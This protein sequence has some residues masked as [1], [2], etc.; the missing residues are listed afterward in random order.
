MHSLLS[1]ENQSMLILFEV[2]A[3]FARLLVCFKLHY[4]SFSIQS[5]AQR[6]LQKLLSYTKASFLLI[7]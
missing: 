7:Y 6:L 2:L 3:S 5:K 4:L 1:C